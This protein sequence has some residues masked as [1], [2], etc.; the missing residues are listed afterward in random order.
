MKL[1]NLWKADI[2]YIYL[3]RSQKEV[4]ITQFYPQ[5]NSIP[6]GYEKSRRHLLVTNYHERGNVVDNRQ[7]MP[8]IVT[9][10]SSSRCLVIAEL[11]TWG[12]ELLLF[13]FRAGLDVIYLNRRTSKEIKAGILNRYYLKTK[14]SNK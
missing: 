12:W 5:R 13:Q 6:S 10:Q 3:S 2:A 11:I 8:S 1:K 14:V 7:A 4:F 9:H